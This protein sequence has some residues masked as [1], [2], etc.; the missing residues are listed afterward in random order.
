MTWQELKARID[1]EVGDS[2]EIW[3]ID[4]HCPT[5]DQFSSGQ[6]DI[7]RDDVLGVRIG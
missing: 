6:I 3:Y 2:E 7:S 1:R 4:I 5:P